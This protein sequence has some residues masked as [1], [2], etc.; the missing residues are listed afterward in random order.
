MHTYEFTNTT[1]VGWT[2]IYINWNVFGIEFWNVCKYDDDDNNHIVLSKSKYI[3]ERSNKQKKTDAYA[4][5][6]IGKHI[7]TREK[8]EKICSDVT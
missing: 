3:Q 7:S 4:P 5:G 1:I 2:H 6:R 8:M